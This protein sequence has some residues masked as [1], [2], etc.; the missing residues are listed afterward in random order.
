MSIYDLAAE[1]AVAVIDYRATV[2]R[3]SSFSDTVATA[4]HLARTAER[5]TAAIADAI[6]ESELDVSILLTDTRPSA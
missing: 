4:N 5:L 2:D 1:T 3:P 6:A